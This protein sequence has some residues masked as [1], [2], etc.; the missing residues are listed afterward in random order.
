MREYIIPANEHYAQGYRGNFLLWK[1]TL[2]FMFMLDESCLYNN[3]EWLDTDKKEVQKI[4][5]FYNGTSEDVSARIGY[6]C[7][8]QKTFRIVLYIRDNGIFTPESELEL[9]M[10]QPGQQATI[11]LTAVVNGYTCDFTAG[12]QKVTKY[13]VANCRPSWIKIKSYPYG[14]GQM[15]VP[16]DRKILIKEI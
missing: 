9:G 14:G 7:L 15:T 2:S 11:R 13:R 10:L 4:Y 3:S 6:Q 5:G 12:D 8:D 1:N 16:H